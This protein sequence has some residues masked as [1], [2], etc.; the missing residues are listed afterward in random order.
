MR[1]SK[2]DKV[3]WKKKGCNGYTSTIKRMEV[4]EKEFNRFLKRFGKYLTVDSYEKRVREE[5]RLKQEQILNQENKFQSRLEE[6]SGDGN[7]KK[8]SANSKSG[9]PTCSGSSSQEEKSKPSS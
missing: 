6:L 7:F 5:I 2:E 4:F 9:S 8:K 3:W 1:I